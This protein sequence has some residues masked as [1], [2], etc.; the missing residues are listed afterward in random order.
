MEQYNY[1]YYCTHLY[2]RFKPTTPQKNPIEKRDKTNKKKNRSCRV[3]QRNG[4]IPFLSPFIHIE[5][6][7]RQRSTGRRWEAEQKKV[8]KHR[9]WVKEARQRR[10]VSTVE[11]TR[12]DR[13][14]VAVTIFG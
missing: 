10:L 14:Q 13:I 11:E 2:I 4:P 5:L 3:R 1:G 9:S 6:Q 8:K 7:G 12:K